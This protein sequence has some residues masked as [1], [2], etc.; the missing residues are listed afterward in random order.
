[1]L[2]KYSKWKRFIY[3]NAIIAPVEEIEH[4]F[5]FIGQLYKAVVLDKMCS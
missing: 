5:L 1:M 4:L 3:N 2:A